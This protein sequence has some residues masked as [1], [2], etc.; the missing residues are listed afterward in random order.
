MDRKKRLEQIFGQF[1]CNLSGSS[2]RV[3]LYLFFR[4][5]MLFVQLPGDGGQ[6]SVGEVSAD[7]SEH[8]VSLRE[9]SQSRETPTGETQTER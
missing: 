3:Q 7:L 8:L 2:A 6:L 1:D 9:L 4:E 5:S